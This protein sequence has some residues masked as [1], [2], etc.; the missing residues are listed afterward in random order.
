MEKCPFGEYCHMLHNIAK[1]HKKKARI[2]DL[3]FFMNSGFKIY[4]YGQK[5]AAI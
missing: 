3:F 1:D 2:F 5:E 4:N